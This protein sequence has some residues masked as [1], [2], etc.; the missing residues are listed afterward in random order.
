MTKQKAIDLL[1]LYLIDDLGEAK[2]NT[3]YHGIDEDMREALSIAIEALSADAVEVVRCKDCKWAK[4]AILD[5]YC[6]K[7]T[8]THTFFAKHGYCHHG[9]KRESHEVCVY[10]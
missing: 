1:S 10:R 3:W 9:E 2:L 4:K 5:E 8:M 7:C 6:V